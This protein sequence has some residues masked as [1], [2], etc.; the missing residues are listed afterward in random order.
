MRDIHSSPNPGSATNT[1]RRHWLG[2]AAAWA[3]LAGTASVLSACGWRFKGAFT[4]NKNKILLLGPG[5]TPLPTPRNEAGRVPDD[6]PPIRYA[7]PTAGDALPERVR[8]VLVRR[9]G[10]ELVESPIQA[11]FVFRIL[12]IKSQTDLV[13]FSGAG[14]TTER[15]VEL[16]ARIIAEG[17]DG[18]PLIPVDTIT[19]R[20]RLSYDDNQTLAG[21]A[22]E[23]SLR[24]NLVED[25]QDRLLGR[26]A[27]L[28]R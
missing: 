6:T 23:Q 8:R 1:A 10:V 25:M 28:A 3:G 18:R 5:Q 19:L 27:A 11:D 7:Q 20:R 17:P 12:E 15:V 14:R 13:G 9:Y 4:F 24:D 26:I 2:R 16:M 21:Q 22:T